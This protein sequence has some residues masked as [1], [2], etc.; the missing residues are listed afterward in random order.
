MHRGLNGS[1]SVLEKTYSDRELPLKLLSSQL[2]IDGDNS[3]L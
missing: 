3:F 2:A 1:E